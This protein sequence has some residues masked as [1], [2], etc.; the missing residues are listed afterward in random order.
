MV[1]LPPGL[2]GS[3]CSPPVSFKE[4]SDSGHGGA[5]E[6]PVGQS[7]LT[8]L[9]DAQES[10]RA[11]WTALFSKAMLG[12]QPRQHPFSFQSPP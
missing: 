8:E 10:Q 1:R 3:G 9:R 7:R 11:S 2:A 4:D 12:G 5:T 6:I